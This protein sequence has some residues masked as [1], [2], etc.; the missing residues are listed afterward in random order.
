VTDT[1]PSTASLDSET[2]LDVAGEARLY[3]SFHHYWHAVLVA[4]ELSDQPVGVTLMGEKIVLVRLDD[5]VNAYADLCPH[6]GTALSLGC[7][8]DNQLRCAYHGWTYQADGRCTSIPARHGSYIPERARL[9][10]YRAAEQAGLIWVCLVDDPIMPIPEL[11]EINDPAYR[12][13]TPAP[14]DWDCSAPRRLE[15]FVDLAHFSW[16]HDGILGD[17]DHPEVPDHEVN[18]TE[19]ELRF[20]YVAYEPASGEIKEALDTTSEMMSVENTYRLTMP[21]TIHLHR[22]L[23]GDLNYVLFMTASP[24]GPTTTR[25]F[26]VLARNYAL[27]T[28][29]SDFVD[30]EERIL[31]QD[32]PVVQSQ[33]PEELPS[34]LTN[35]LH[36]KGV[37]LV[38]LEYR[39]RLIELMR[40]V[41]T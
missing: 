28:P 12:I 32:M 26:W 10:R 3:E 16:V 21:L 17:R 31:E 23:G 27:D 34:D 5:E 13:V 15:N 2:H 38:S 36:I 4:A 30:F 1:R 37:D 7:V 9:R 39:R 6:R 33:R 24:V 35:E 11:P 14:Y 40:G 18:R 19:S 25:S 41:S 29:D 8:E 22:H 20:H